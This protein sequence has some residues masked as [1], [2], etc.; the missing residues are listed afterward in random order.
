MILPNVGFIGSNF[1]I[2]NMVAFGVNNSIYSAVS[3]AFA[4]LD[5]IARSLAEL[6]KFLQRNTERDS[7]SAVPG[8]FRCILFKIFVPVINWIYYPPIYAIMFMA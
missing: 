6:A 1:Y 5:Y 2:P 3:A 4:L 8:T 7:Y